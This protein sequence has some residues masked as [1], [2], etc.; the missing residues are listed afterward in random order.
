MLDAAPSKSYAFGSV[1]SL[2]TPDRELSFS[3][4]GL[5]LSPQVYPI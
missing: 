1:I 3:A 5:I 4:R 2:P